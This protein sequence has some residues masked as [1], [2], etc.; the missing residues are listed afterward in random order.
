VS[1]L[2]ASVERLLD[3]ADAD[4]I[5]VHR[6][7]ALAARRL[8]RLGRPVPPGLHA[9]ER[10]AKTSALLTKPLLE[11]IRPSCDGPLVL[12]KGPEVAQLYPGGARNFSD[13]DLLVPDARRVHDAL[14]SEGFVEVDDPE[15]FVDHHH[16][17][18]LLAPGLGLKV[19]IHVGLPWPAGIES[20]DLAE[21]VDG[22]GPSKTGVDGI[23]APD[24]VHHALI[25]AAHAWTHDPLGTLRD[26]V[27]VAA[28]AAAVPEPEL[29]RAARGWGIDRVWRTTSGVAGALLD[30]RPR[31]LPLRVWAGHLEGVRERTV[32]ENH[33]ERWLHSFSERPPGAA[34]GATASVLRQELLPT[35]GEPWRDKLIR[36]GRAFRHP[37]APL[38][39]HIEGWRKAAR[40]RR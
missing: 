10:A 4:G 29:D 21:I 33:L 15:L 26:V 19:E 14:K 37:R 13:V 35:P 5:L 34:F 31:P 9:A 17:R 2:W 20:P 36:V 28:V 27:D 6:L 16:L 22:A 11:R 40:D 25:L 38:S 7:G 32:L 3:G 24:P 23:S 18:P 1:E 39:S 8:R 30:G 12:I